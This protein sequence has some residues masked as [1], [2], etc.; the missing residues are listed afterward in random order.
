MS[1]YG[2]GAGGA[3][4]QGGMGGGGI[5]GFVH[6]FDTRNPPAYGRIPD[7]EN[8]F[9]SVLVDGKGNIQ[10]EGYEECN[11]YRIVTNEGV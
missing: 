6:V 2:S 4:T 8:I 11:A 1:S 10:K 5:G 3:N 9:G 7:P